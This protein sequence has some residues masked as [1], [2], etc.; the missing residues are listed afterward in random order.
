MNSSRFALFSLAV[1]ALAAGFLVFPSVAGACGGPSFPGSCRTAAA[2][3]LD[4][5]HWFGTLVGG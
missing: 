4:A 1:S 5:L 3:L 2:L